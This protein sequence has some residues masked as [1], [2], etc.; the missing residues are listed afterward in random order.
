MFPTRPPH[1]SRAALLL[2]I[3][4][5]AAA[6][7][8]SAEGT[9]ATTVTDPV[10]LIDGLGE[11]HYAISTDDSLAQ[12]YFD[13]GLRLTYAFNHAEAV[14]AFDEAARLDPDC[15]MCYWG[16][17]LALGP[18]INVPMDS[19][20]GARAYEAVRKALAAS[21]AT[22][23]ERA[24]IAALAERYTAVPPANRATLDSAYARAMADVVRRYPD[25][26][27]AATLYAE[28]MMDLTPWNYWTKDAKPRTGTAEILASLER[29]VDRNPMHPGAC[30]F[31]IHAV[32]AMQPDRAVPCA[33]RLAATMPAAGHIVH[34]PGHIYIRVGRYADAIQANIHAVHADETYIGDQRPS[35]V[36][37]AM[38][39]PHNYHFLA[40]AAML[41][42]RS[43]QALDA[44]ARVVEKTPP[45]LARA[46]PELQGLVPYRHLLL[47][48]FGRWEEVIA[49]P[50]PPTDLRVS[51][52]LA[53]Y[54]RG[55][56]FS[57]SGRPAEAAAAL[58]SVRHSASQVVVE[59]A[60]TVLTIA[61]RALAGD[62]A[63]KRGD[64]QKGIADLRAAVELEDQLSYMEPPYW[65]QPVRHLLGAALLD[66]GRNAE[67]ERV[68]L[69]DLRKLPEN[70]WSLRGLSRALVAQNK[71]AEAAEV[72][73]R[74]ETTWGGGDVRLGSSRF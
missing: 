52:G 55:L 32:E 3:L 23:R 29:V 5:F 69:E 35:G 65:H 54:A 70:G 64:T 53:H 9:D 41:S 28:A 62:I 56:A 17:A 1:A 26:L 27:E 44:A 16:T 20:S 58:D 66:I 73:E 71:L 10:P 24:L 33:E 12:R 72:D 51:T 67:A 74:Y 14:R 48:T 38:Y 60:R 11:H 37:P 50:V 8:T 43:Q 49:A 61:V 34:M 42:G 39:Y 13:Q 30:H 63:L 68:Y 21:N 19:A 57:A 45:E 2:P 59:P 6:C 47:A 46:V 22:E 25:D 36:Y 4:A 18:N 40:F 31:Y 7:A 15:A